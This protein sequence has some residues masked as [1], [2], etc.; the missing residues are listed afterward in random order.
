MVNLVRKINRFYGFNSS[1]F[2][3]S[4]ILLRTQSYKL[5]LLGQYVAIGYGH[6][7][8]SVMILGENGR[9][10]TAVLQLSINLANTQS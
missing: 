10:I 2:E 4:P 9:F 3:L 1:L 8:S 5:R 7:Q 6:C